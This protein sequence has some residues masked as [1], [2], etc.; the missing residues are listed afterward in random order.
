M[1]TVPAVEIGGS[2]VSATRVD[3]TT[4]RALAAPPTRRPL[5]PQA[6]ATD[7]I[8]AVADCAAGSGPFPGTPLR[9]A[10]PG[11]FDYPGGI[12]W[13]EGVGKFDALRGLDV[14]A[15]LGAALPEPPAEITFV[16]DAVAFAAGEWV[17][18]A[19]RGATR[20]VGITLGTGVGSAFLDRGR[21][22]QAGPR[23][24]PEGRVDL[25]RVDGRP[26]EDVVSTRAVVTAAGSA[27]TGV[28]DVVRAART[29]SL[30][31]Q[32][33]L[34]DAYHRLG[35]VLGPWVAGFGADTLVVGGAVVGSWDVIGPP[36]RDGL[37]AGGCAVE[38]RTAALPGTAAHVG[39]VWLGYTAR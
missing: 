35:V 39:A 34:R 24:P 7:L 13:Y 4:W 33:V 11:P 16:N 31:A 32:G 17:A 30:A 27:T 8:A 6:A 23:V 2:H 26:L 1:R 14:R 22:V 38:V 10:L 20:I 19:G 25:L 37:A 36:L 3:T 5:N 9:V 29:G 28:R 12:A 15:A 18:G 21:P